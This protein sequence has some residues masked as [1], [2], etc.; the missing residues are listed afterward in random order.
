MRRRL[1]IFGIIVVIIGLIVGGFFYFG[2]RKPPSC[3]DGKQ[4][5]SEEGIDCGGPCPYL[6]T[7]SQTPPSVRFVRPV[8]PLPGRTDVVAYIDNPN[9]TSAIH[10]AHYTIE[11]YDANNAVVASK[12]GTVDL[13]PASTA[14]VFVPNFF[15]GSRTATHAFLTFDQSSMHWYQY[16]ETRILPKVIDIVPTEGDAPR[17]TATIT[18]PS[19]ETLTDVLLIATVFDADGNA[20]A[21]SQTVAPTVPAQGDA[22]IIFTWPMPFPAPVSKVEIVPVTQASFAPSV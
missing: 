5:Q 7:M 15:S 22:P 18:N 11:L 17:V 9:S 20:M 2:V 21:A 16:R 4:N 8:S 10:N 6:C 14:A 19:A 3:I 13:L 1:F 12:E